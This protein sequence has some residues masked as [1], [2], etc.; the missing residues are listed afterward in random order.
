MMLPEFDT[1]LA[2]Q[3]R[4][5]KKSIE[6]AVRLKNGEEYTADIE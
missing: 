1:R 4:P 6:E 3:P 5:L 2:S